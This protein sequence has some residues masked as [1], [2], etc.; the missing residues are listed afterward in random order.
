MLFHFSAKTQC[1][2]IGNLSNWNQ[3]KVRNV[4]IVNESGYNEV[5]TAS[6]AGGRSIIWNTSDFKGNW[7]SK[8]KGKCLC[9]DYKLALNG[10]P[11][12][13]ELLTP[14]FIL[15]KGQI[16]DGTIGWTNPSNFPV[17]PGDV[18]VAKFNF[19]TEFTAENQWKKFCIPISKSNNDILPSDVDG[20]W[21][22]LKTGNG[23]NSPA[24]AWDNLIQNVSGIVLFSDYHG[25]ASEQI[26][27][28]NFNSCIF[29]YFFVKKIILSSFYCSFYFCRCLN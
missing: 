6:D 15:Y 27:F 24:Q 4:Q 10:A 8:Y 25:S 1:V 21:E 9:F 19:A 3:D 26:Y 5:I 7:N 20:S 11:N 29:Q 22:I 16:N 12:N 2:S 18:I 13:G 28:S 14:K 23:T 17:P